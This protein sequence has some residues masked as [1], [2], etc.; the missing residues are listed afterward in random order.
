MWVYRGRAFQAV[1]LACAKAL[2]LECAQHAG[3]NG[4]TSVAGR[5]GARGSIG[6]R[7]GRR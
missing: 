1:G 7:E 5:K 2:G 4:G 3:G 6:G